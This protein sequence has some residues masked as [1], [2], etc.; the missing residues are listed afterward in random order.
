MESF[1]IIP[2][3]LALHVLSVVLWIGGVAFVTTVLLPALVRLPA[4]ERFGVFMEIER[5]FGAQARILVIVAGA[6][7]A[8]LMVR[9]HWLGLLGHLQTWWLDAMIALWILFALFLF[10]LEPGL[11]HRRL[12]RLAQQDSERARILLLR[13]HTILL[14]VAIVVIVGAVLGAQGVA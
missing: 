2:I 11:L 7:G 9:Q 1:P 13:G 3:L 4:S 14:I 6:T 8:D 12:A 10:V 5:R